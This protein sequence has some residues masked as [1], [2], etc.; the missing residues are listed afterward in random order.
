MSYDTNGPRVDKAPVS[1]RSTTSRGWEAEK[2][3]LET[4]ADYWRA[5][6][7]RA[8]AERDHLREQLRDLRAR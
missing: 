1:A 5:R 4:K 2:I 7:R 8:E 6:A 3:D